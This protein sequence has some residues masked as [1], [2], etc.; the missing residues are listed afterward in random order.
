MTAS[1]YDVIF[2]FLAAGLDDLGVDWILAQVRCENG[3]QC[4]AQTSLSNETSC[5]LRFHNAGEHLGA[6]G[7]QGRAIR[8]EANVGSNTEDRWTRR[9]PCGEILIRQ[10]PD[11]DSCGNE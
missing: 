2:H 10:Q 1:E 9:D 11:G 8:K 7:E 3:I 5:L 4:H 6:T